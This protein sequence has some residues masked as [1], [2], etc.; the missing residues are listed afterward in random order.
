VFNTF[1]VFKY[2]HIFNFCIIDDN[3]AHY[4]PTN[5]PPLHDRIAVHRR[6]SAVK[7]PANVVPRF[8]WQGRSLL[9]L[10]VSRNHSQFAE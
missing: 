4:V 1:C 2:F 6:Q 3:N 8:N 5:F 9:A 10:R 7:R